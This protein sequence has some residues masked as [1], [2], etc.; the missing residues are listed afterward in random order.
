MT[1]QTGICGHEVKFA[2][3]DFER[4]EADG[5]FCGYASLFGREDLGHDIIMPGAFK[6]SLERQ[7]SNGIRMLFQHDPNQPVGVWD[8]I[9]E[10]ER[11]LFV[12]GRLTLDVAKAREVHALMKDGGLNGLSIGYKTIKG[13]REQRSGVRRLYEVD[14]WE[15]SVVTFPMLPEAQVSAVKSVGKNSAQKRLP[16]TREFEQWLMRDAGLSRKEARTVIRS[17]FKSLAS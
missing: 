14:L 16:T 17:G 7:S 6:K 10:D 3:A 11:G 4:V 1:S 15:I 8:V 5:T 2:H 9:R 12:K 13:K